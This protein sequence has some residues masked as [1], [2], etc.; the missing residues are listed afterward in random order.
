MVVVVAG[1]RGASDRE[2]RTVSVSA[3]FP[4]IMSCHVYID[5]Y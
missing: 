4:S 2:R 5:V 3:H 1:R